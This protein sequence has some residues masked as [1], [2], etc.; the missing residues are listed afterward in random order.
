MYV[1]LL[2]TMG[3]M[4]SDR[5]ETTS[6]LC[7]DEHSLF[8]LDAGTGLR[9]L[10]EPPQVA[11]LEGRDEIHL[12]L[13]HYHLDHVCGLAY[14]PGVLPGRRLVIHAASDALT[15]VDPERAV[16]GLLRKPYNPRDWEDLDDI[17]V[18]ALEAGLNQVAGHAVRV[19]AQ[20]HTDVSV[21]YRFDDEL[22]LATDTRADAATAEFAAGARLLLH[23]AWYN[24][25]D[26]QTDAAPPQLRP[27]YASHSEA[28]AVARIAA[29]A[30]VGRLVLMHLNPLHDDAYH[31]RLAAAA[32]AVFPRTELHQDGTVL[33]TG[34]AV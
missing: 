14:L 19:R 15:G 13:T 22:V 31:Q 21:A 9:R 8:I 28:T 25:A 7:H 34:A 10:L 11:L 17:R 18:E 26:P 24:G 3:W 4:P 23:E 2:G 29:D 16:A 5:R 33:D 27:G 20:Q 30:D 6:F 1:T 12:F 32:R